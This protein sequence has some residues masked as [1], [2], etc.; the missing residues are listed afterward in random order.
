MNSGKWIWFSDNAGK[1]EYGEFFTDFCW[2]GK[3][4]LRLQLS[5]DGDYTLFINGVYVSSNQYG[6]YEHYKIYDE[7]DVTSFLRIGKNVMF[8]LVWHIGEDT[9]KYKFY[10]AGLIF[11]LLQGNNVVVESDENTLCRKS[12]TYQ[13]GYC[14]WISPQMGY[15]FLYNATKEANCCFSQEGFVPATLVEK[16][17]KFFARPNQKLVI[18]E[19]AEAVCLEAKELHY[20]IDLGK[21]T[22]GLPTLQFLSPCEQKITVAWG[23]DLQDGHV[24][25]KIDYP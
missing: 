18:G 10:K 17:C 13:S 2:N 16:N 23:E 3:E 15:S 20:I 24:R 11:S 7:I 14:K 9:S 25:Q 1:D 22:V 4:K 12:L 6:D 8:I 21:E 5:V 19:R